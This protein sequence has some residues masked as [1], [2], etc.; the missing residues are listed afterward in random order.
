M[1]LLGSRGAKGERGGHGRCM[2][3]VICLSSFRS[4]QRRDPREEKKI[5]K[6]ALARLLSTELHGERHAFDELE[7]RRP[8]KLQ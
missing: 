3:F 8:C 7:R 2:I 4:K 5:V 1:G 6:A